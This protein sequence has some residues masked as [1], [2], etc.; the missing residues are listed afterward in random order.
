MFETVLQNE[1]APSNTTQA[2]QTCLSTW[3]KFL[4]ELQKF[5]SQ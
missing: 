4:H 2:W 1:L 3:Q 5:W